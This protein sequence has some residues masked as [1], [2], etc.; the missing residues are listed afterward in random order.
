[1]EVIEI[2]LRKDAEADLVEAGLTEG[3]ECLR[4]EG[5]GLQMPDIAGGAY[6]GVRGAVCVGEMERVLYVDGTVVA[7]GRGVDKESA[8]LRGKGEGGGELPAVSAFMGR[9]ET[10]A[11]EAVPVI[12]AADGDGFFPAGKDRGKRLFRKR[13]T[14]MGAG[15]N[16]FIQP[17]TFA[18]KRRRK[19]V[20]HE[21]NLLAW[22]KWTDWSC[23]NS[24]PQTGGC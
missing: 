13:I 16:D 9:H 5:I 23:E 3:L 24:I 18:G 12:K 1:M 20:T 14:G 7:C 2:M 22:V 8:L 15:K 19:N 4:N 11:V 17:P 6:R 10:N 21:N